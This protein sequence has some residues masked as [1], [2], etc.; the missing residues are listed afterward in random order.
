MM[1][2]I[3]FSAY[4]EAGPDFTNVTTLIEV[5]LNDGRVLGG[6]A[7]HAAG[8]TR[9]PMSFAEVADKYRQCARYGGQ[10][11]DLAERTVAEVAVIERCGDLGSL[12]AL[13][14]ASD[15]AVH[16]GTR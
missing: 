16:S 6:R 11:D 7:D 8:S 9:A 2:R 15:D 14:K 3:A 5:E 12:T 1:K 13:L 10:A 4:D